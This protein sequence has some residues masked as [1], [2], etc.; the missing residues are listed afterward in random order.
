[1]EAANV[2]YKRGNAVRFSRC[3]VDFLRCSRFCLDGT[4]ED[5]Q[6]VLFG[7]RLVVG[8]S[9]SNRSDEVCVCQ[10]ARITCKRK[11]TPI[12][13]RMTLNGE[14][15]KWLDAYNGL[16]SKPNFETT[17]SSIVLQHARCH[18]IS[19]LLS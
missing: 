16:D 4:D 9:D 10:I 17:A 7:Q 3:L 5:P 12:P 13:V 6:S 14:R 1:M 15:A 18:G 2:I 19:I 8:Q 11:L